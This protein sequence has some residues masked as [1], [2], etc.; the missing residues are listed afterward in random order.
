M[1]GIDK[2]STEQTEKLKKG[3]WTMATNPSLILVGPN[4]HSETGSSPLRPSWMNNGSFLV[5]RKLE[6]DVAKFKAFTKDKF[7]T[8][9]CKTEEEFGAKLMGRDKAGIYLQS[10]TTISL[11]P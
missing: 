3:A 5:F 7:L 1:R 10:C 4:T 11:K 2:L 8:A 9:G 6:Q